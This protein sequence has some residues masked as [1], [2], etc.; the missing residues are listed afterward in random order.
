MNTTI[1]VSDMIMAWNHW[2]QN[3]ISEEK[4]TIV[5]YL[6]SDDK[7]E[8]LLAV[9]YKKVQGRHQRQKMTDEEIAMYE[10]L[11]GW[12]WGKT[13][14]AEFGKK[15]QAWARFYRLNGGKPPRAS[16]NASSEE[17]SLANWASRVQRSKN[18]GTLP[19]Q[20]AIQLEKTEGWVWK[21]SI[22]TAVSFKKRLEAWTAFVN[23]HGRMPLKS[24]DSDLFT[25][26]QRMVANA[27]KGKMSEETQQQLSELPCWEWSAVEHNIKIGKKWSSWVRLNEGSFP[28]PHST[29]NPVEK[30]LGMWAVEMRDAIIQHKVDIT[31]CNE[32]ETFPYWK[33][34]MEE[35]TSIIF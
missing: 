21:K 35:A 18:K 27:I 28:S 3:K 23:E 13:R 25:W 33:S 26:R 20:Q 17:K 11:P 4:Q 8:R 30:K 12:G 7:Q 29:T 6:G 22:G 32:L 2:V 10:T 9:W 1:A 31:I 16:P 24:D 34:F 14:D 5:P 19:E 15:A